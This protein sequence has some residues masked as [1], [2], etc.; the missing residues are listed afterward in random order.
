MTDS[1]ADPIAASVRA[2]LGRAKTTAR[3]VARDL[4]WDY[5]KLIRRVS[6]EVPFSAAELGRIADYLGVPVTRFYAA[7]DH[8]TTTTQETAAAS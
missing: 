8:P 7:P 4:E 2:E 3:R 6:G 5:P 1:P